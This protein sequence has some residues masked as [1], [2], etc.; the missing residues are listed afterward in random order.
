VVFSSQPQTALHYFV[1]DDLGLGGGAPIEGSYGYGGLAV[2]IDLDGDLDLVT[3]VR[4][5]PGLG[6]GSFGPARGVDLYGSPT[7]TADLN[8][9]GWPDIVGTNRAEG[10]LGIGVV[11][12]DGQ[13]GF[14]PGFAHQRYT[15]P[16]GVAMLD[17][18]GD[19]RVD[20]VYGDS[21]HAPSRLCYGPNVA[22]NPDV[23]ADGVPDAVDTC[24]DKDGDGFADRLTDTSACPLDNCA[25]TPNTNQSD[26]DGD[27]RGDA[28]DPCPYDA[29]DDSDRD[30]VCQ[31]VDVCPGRQDPAQED[32]DGDGVG[33]QCDNCPTVASAD[34]SDR[35]GDG[36]GDACQPVVSILGILEDGGAEL[37]VTA[38]VADPENQVLDGVIRI[39][40]PASSYVLSDAVTSP[41]CGRRLP[42]ESIA[43]RGIVFAVIDG[44][45]FLAD[46]DLLAGAGLI[47]G[48]DD[49]VPD[50]TLTL[51]RCS[52]P[53]SVADN[54]L[55]LDGAGAAIPGPI[56]IRRADGSASFDMHVDYEG[57]GV[58]LDGDRPILQETPYHGVTV[59]DL[60]PIGG[61]T[62]LA[63][64]RLEITATDGITPVVA[65]SREFQYHGEAAIR[66]LVPGAISPRPGRERPP[67]TGRAGP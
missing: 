33:D 47:P 8:G 7:A 13:G 39:V 26:S 55:D 45:R 32:Q 64:Y 43:G 53:L 1:G 38:L 25:M 60:V 19:G 14:E 2:D 40:D 42:P 18:D 44:G 34:Q 22:G 67:A 4:I 50:Y 37:E 20:T 57:S 11:L 62:P 12:S 59:P 54:F 24:I 56:C 51:G 63:T 27:G 16:G 65:G 3:G 35:D 10:G 58:R 5:I 36:A 46:A 21:W 52:A 29:L 6:N 17:A 61:L 15:R 49:G 31:G 23:D 66:F 48:C 41:D 30:G 9:D 28:C